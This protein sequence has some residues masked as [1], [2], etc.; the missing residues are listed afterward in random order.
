MNKDWSE[1]NKE[2]QVLIGKAATLADGIS[3]LIDLRNDLL[4]QISYVVYG[5]PSE[6]FYQ[7]P[8]AGAAGYQ[9]KTLAYS[10]WH[11]FRIEDIVAHTLIGGDEQV[12]FAGGWQEKIGSPIITTGNELRGEEIAQ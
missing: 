6:A 2:M 5:Y 10:M 8:F 12:L 1:K 9:S 4:T 11:I 3:V 7:M